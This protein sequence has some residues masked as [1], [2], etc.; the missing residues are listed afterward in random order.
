M[1]YD[2]LNE[3]GMKEVGSEQIAAITEDIISEHKRPATGY[4]AHVL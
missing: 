3:W 2:V 4:K 1:P